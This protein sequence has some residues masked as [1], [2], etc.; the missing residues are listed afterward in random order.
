MKSLNI[1]NVLEKARCELEL[2]KEEIIYLL[3]LTKSEER[4]EVFKVSKELRKKYFNNKVFLYGFVY[5]ST[6]CKND[7]TFCFYRKSNHYCKRYRKTEKEIVDL[8]ESLGESGINLIDLT[9]GEDPK[10]HCNNE[11]GYEKLI[12]IVSSVR[13]KV[14]LPIMI[15]PGVVPQNVLMGLKKAGADWYACYQ[16]THSREKYEKLRINQSYD[17]RW[18][19]KISAKNLGLLIEEGLLVG[20]WSSL[21]DI[22]DS[23]FQMKKLGAQQVRTMSF[24]PQKGTPLF[25]QKITDDLLELNIIAVMRLLFPDKLIPA[26]LDVEGIIGLKERLEAGANVVTSIIPPKGGLVGVSQSTLNIDDGNRTVKGVIPILRESG[27]IG[28]TKEEYM[29]WVDKAKKH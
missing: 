6:Y 1:D 28:A 23:M 27:L 10:Y 4:C 12:K 11:K 29:Q 15:S 21:D 13:D 7:C 20:Y 16:E 2:S 9:M 3:S 18:N 14:K 22:A 5:F 17:E 26:S 19:T 24:V 8:A 25:S